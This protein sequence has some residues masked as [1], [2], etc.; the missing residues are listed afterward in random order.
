VQIGILGGTG[1]A[2]K[3]LAAR[4]ASVG[5]EVVIGSRSRYRAME[6]RDQ[7]AREHGIWMFNRVQHAALPGTSMCELYVGDN[8]LAAS[9]ARIREALSIFAGALEGRVS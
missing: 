3:A 4:L 1:P 9:E 7:L 2:G 5:F 8:L 6:I